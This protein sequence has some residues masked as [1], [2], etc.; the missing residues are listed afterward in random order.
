MRPGEIVTLIGANGAGKSTTLRS[1]NGL[2]HPREGRITFQGRDITNEPAHDVVKMGI[3]QSPEG[4]RLFPRMSVLENLEM[5]AFQREDRS[6]LREDLERVY[7]LF[8]RLQERRQQKA[9]TLSGGEQQM[10]AIGR[11]LMARPKLLMLDEPS[12]GLAPIFVEKIFEI[13]L[14]INAQG[15]PILLVEQ[16]ALMA[17]DVAS[18][19]FVLE[20]GSIALADDAEEAPRRTSRSAR[21]TS[22]SLARPTPVLPGPVGARPHWA[23]PGTVSGHG[24]DV[25]TRTGSRRMY[26]DCPRTWPSW[27]RQLTRS[28]KYGGERRKPMRGGRSMRPRAIS[29]AGPIPCVGTKPS[30]RAAVASRQPATSTAPSRLSAGMHAAQSA[31]GSSGWHAAPP[32]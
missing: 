14:E 24:R 23:R 30:C 2:N 5:G 15:T 9:G 6:T 20:T 19:G 12:M 22:A 27:D 25:A 11:A 18:R 17:L 13:I 31:N 3:A 8:P 21:P 26:G 10:V 29:R 32:R 16:N 7:Q 28:G 1:I 4:R